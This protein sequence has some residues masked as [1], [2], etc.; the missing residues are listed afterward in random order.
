MKRQ[1]SQVTVQVVVSWCGGKAF[2]IQRKCHEIRDPFMV[3][4]RERKRVCASTSQLHLTLSYSLDFVHSLTL[5]HSLT[6]LIISHHH[7]NHLLHRCLTAESGA[8]G[9][10]PP[11]VHVS[12]I[13]EAHHDLCGWMC[14][15]AEKKRGKRRMEGH[16]G[17]LCLSSEDEKGKNLKIRA[18]KKKS[19]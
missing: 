14:Y 15:I 19:M 16:K 11:Q 10:V 6:L 8:D 2:E 5:T 12:D 17:S 18:G 3:V 7:R 1:R 13:G 9:P 4:R